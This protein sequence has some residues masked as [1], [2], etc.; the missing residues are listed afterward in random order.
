MNH[1]HQIRSL[2]LRFLF[3][4]GSGVEGLGGTPYMRAYQWRI[5]GRGALSKMS[6]PSAI[7]SC[8]EVQGISDLTLPPKIM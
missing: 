8:K 3:Q 7:F 4:A 2:A 5:L 1:G 6:E